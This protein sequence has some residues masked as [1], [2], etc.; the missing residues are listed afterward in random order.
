M[1]LSKFKESNAKMSSSPN[2]RASNI[3][4]LPS[5]QFSE[6]LNEQHKPVLKVL[7][8][9]FALRA[10]LNTS[11]FFYY[12]IKCAGTYEN[13]V[14]FNCATKAMMSIIMLIILAGASHFNKQR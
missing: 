1:V 3:E 8:V 13:F 14:V 12:T 10:L 6:Y 9:F 11:K 4:K 7:C 5:N 2:F